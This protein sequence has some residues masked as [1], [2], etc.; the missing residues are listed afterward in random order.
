[1]RVLPV[2]DLLHGQVVRG[3]A[4]ERENYRPI[5]SQLASDAKPESIARAFAEFGFRECYV[6][7]LNA[8][9][10]G[11][12]HW[13]AYAAMLH[14]GLELWIDAGCAEQALAKRLASFEVAGRGLKRILVGLESLESPDRMPKLVEC[15][16]TERIVFSLDLKHGR[17]LTRID[18]WRTL[19]PLEIARR[20]YAC[21]ARSFVILDLAAVGTNG[22]PATTTLCEDLRRASPDVEL[23][24]GGGVRNADDLR[25]FAKAGC[26]FALV[27]SALHDGRITQP[28]LGEFLS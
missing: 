25:T 10:G 6:A 15:I 13:D 7:D 3:I 27:A 1:M 18:D 23:I 21:G 20:V 12:P 11:E 4:G 5:Q 26:D 8:I 19:E 28:E 22:G 16:D 17:P 9:A 2:I 14:H 24:S